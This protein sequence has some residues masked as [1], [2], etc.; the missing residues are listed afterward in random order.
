MRLLLRST[1]RTLACTVDT[2]SRQKQTCVCFCARL[3]VSLTAPKIG[4]SAK[5]QINLPSHPAY[6]YLLANVMNETFLSFPLGDDRPRTRGVRRTP[7]RRSGI[8][9]P[10]QPK[11]RAGHPQPYR[12]DGDGVARLHRHVH[13]VA[14]LRPCTRSG[15]AGTF[16][17]L[18]EPLPATVLRLPA[19]DPREVAD[20]AGNRSDGNGIQYAQRP[21]AGR[22]D[23]LRLPPPAT[24]TVGSHVPTSGS[25]VRCSSP[26]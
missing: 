7:F 2:P 4:R 19:A 10:L 25:A 21:D 22:L 11:I 16:H 13:P 24:T 14:L 15:T 23:L 9:L 26:A 12:M 18:P 1:F 5:T 20:A 8:R 6:S 17:P 3:F